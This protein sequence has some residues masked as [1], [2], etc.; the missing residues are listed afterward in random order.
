MSCFVLFF[1][2]WPYKILCEVYVKVNNKIGAW[3]V[4]IKWYF[5]PRPRLWPKIMPK[6][7]GQHISHNMSLFFSDLKEKENFKLQV[8]IIRY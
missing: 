2:D 1:S 4:Y 3:I 8:I 5:L 7:K 6:S